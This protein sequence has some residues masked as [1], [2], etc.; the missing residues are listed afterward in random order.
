MVQINLTLPDNLLAAAEKYVEA[1]GFKNVQD[2]AA[3]AIREK[4]FEDKDDD[5]T[6]EEMKLA[7]KIIK[8]ALKSGIGTEKELDEALKI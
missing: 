1:F 4:V 5:L 2:L 7:N 8:I 3:E 6:E